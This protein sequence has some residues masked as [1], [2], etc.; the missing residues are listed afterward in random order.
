MAH[1]GNEAMF[2]GELISEKSTDTNL[3]SQVDSLYAIHSLVFKMSD[4]C[5]DYNKSGLDYSGV[6]SAIKAKM[7]EINTIAKRL[8][9]LNR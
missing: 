4:L 5:N 9:D 8:E 1:E 7:G 3:K 6:L 2:L